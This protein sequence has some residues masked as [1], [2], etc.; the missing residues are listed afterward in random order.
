[1]KGNNLLAPNRPVVIEWDNNEG[2]IF[3]KKN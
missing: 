2:L 1:V 3:T